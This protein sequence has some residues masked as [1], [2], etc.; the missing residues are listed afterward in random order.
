MG[1]SAHPALISLNAALGLLHVMGHAG[2]GGRLRIVGVVAEHLGQG[3]KD[4]DDQ[5]EQRCETQNEI[6]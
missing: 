2:P 1:L 5:G 4:E 6:P 3:N